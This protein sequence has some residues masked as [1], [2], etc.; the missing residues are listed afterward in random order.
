MNHQHFLALADGEVFFGQSC[1]APVDASGEVVFNTGMTGYQEIITD[2]SYAG[3]FV[4]FT[5]PEIGNYGCNRN[6]AQS[7]GVFLSGILLRNMNPA[8]NF[9]AESSL[10]D[11]MTDYGKPALSGLDTRR[12]VLHLRERGVQKAWL[13][14]SNGPLTPEE[15]VLLAQRWEGLD[16]KDTASAVSTDK[17]YRWNEDGARR[18]VVYDFGVKYDILRQLALAGF[19]VDVVPASTPPATVWQT[20]PDALFLSNGPGDPRGVIGAVDVAR[21]FLGRIPVMGI[22]LGHQILALACGASCEK[23]KFGH[24]GC[25][26]PVLALADNRVAI[27]SQNHN[28]AVLESSLPDSL[29]LTHINLNDRTVE[30][31]RHRE[32]P[33]FAVQYH[34]EAAPGPNDSLSLFRQFFDLVV[35]S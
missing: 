12:L 7:R 11:Y 1:A 33:M 10:Q 3:Q 28:Y 17:A 32:L 27:T 8:S 35:N 16:H 18:V 21:F 15:G 4:V 26:H 20:K 24:H 22:C 9:A 5:A 23:L 30:G 2:P 25:N 34:P 29:E 13:H 31:F 6:D 19:Q 14:A